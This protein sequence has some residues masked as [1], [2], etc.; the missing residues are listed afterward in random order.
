MAAAGLGSK[1]A[2]PALFKSIYHHLLIIASLEYRN[3]LLIFI[4]VYQETARFGPQLE[5][6]HILDEISHFKTHSSHFKSVSLV[7]LRRETHVLR[8]PK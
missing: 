2:S 4:I 6:N 7:K 8:V 1:F 3:G 5:K